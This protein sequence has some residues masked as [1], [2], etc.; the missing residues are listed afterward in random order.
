M[1][2]YNQHDPSVM[3][4]VLQ[5]TQLSTVDVTVLRED[6]QEA[7]QAKFPGETSIQIANN[8]CYSGKSMQLE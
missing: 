7:L 6:I 4:P 5:T 1:V 2:A 3:K 8:L